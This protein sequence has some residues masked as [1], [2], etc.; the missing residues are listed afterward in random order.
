[1]TI[2]YT[3]VMNIYK[4]FVLGILGIAVL[5]MGIMWTI[6]SLAQNIEAD[7]G[8]PAF[9]QP[10]ITFYKAEVRT[11]ITTP[12]T[13]LGTEREMEALIINGDRSGEIIHVTYYL[14]VVSSEEYAYEIGDRI[15]VTRSAANDSVI[16]SVVDRYRIPGIVLI[17]GIFV[18]L[19][20]VLARKRGITSLIGLA[21]SMFMLIK[22]L[23]PSIAGGNN[24][25]LIGLA[26]AL[27]IGVVSIY[28]SHGF[29][30]PTSIA[31]GGT[32]ITTVIAMIAATTFV[33]ISKLFGT[34]SEE[35]Y[36]L[37]QFGSIE[38]L[39][40]RGILLVGIVIGCI[41]VLDDITTSLTASIVE[42]K[43]ANANYSLSQLF[44]S[45]LAIGR[46]HIASLV[47]TLVLAYAGASLPLMLIFTIDPRPWWVLLNSQFI[48]EEIIRALVGS[49]A[50]MLAVP[51][52]AWLAAYVYTRQN[53]STKKSTR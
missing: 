18:G 45:G 14:P 52:T 32:I 16:Y 37:Q 34:G 3:T 33:Y 1:M 36:T 26:G 17:I 50:L 43:K 23:V 4:N 39:D 11:I 40:L 41:G 5:T 2:C 7:S 29:N 9:A 49:V 25:V 51:I 15:V 42:I 10:D 6:P 19:A 20:V 30:K 28:I 24:P 22:V 46:E 8:D 27:A 31:V 47:N 12:N 21:F 44:T 53:T 35:A 13:A 38:N 48:A